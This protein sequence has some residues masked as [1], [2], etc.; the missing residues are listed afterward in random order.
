MS[1]CPAA[2][3]RTAS[4]AYAFGFP[5]DVTDI[6]YSCRDFQ[7][8][9]VKAAGGTPSALALQPFR[10]VRD[11]RR[12]LIHVKFRWPVPNSSIMWVAVRVMGVSWAWKPELFEYLKRYGHGP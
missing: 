10:L 6:I 2:A 3:L 1:G 9:E 11:D 4:M 8:E 12:G 5:K 7:F